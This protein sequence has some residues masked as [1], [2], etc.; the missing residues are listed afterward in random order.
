MCGVRFDLVRE[1][2]DAELDARSYLTPKQRRRIKREVRA[3]QYA[4][5]ARS[6]G[7][8]RERMRRSGETFREKRA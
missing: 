4:A 6:G 7:G 2:A 3:M 1:R 8:E 5:V